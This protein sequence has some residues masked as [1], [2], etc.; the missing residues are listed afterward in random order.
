MKL[1]FGESQNRIRSMALIHEVLY[2]STDLGAVP[3][4]EYSRML[5]HQLMSAYAV[6]DVRSNM[7][8]Q[9][10]S[11]G[12]DQ[13]IPCG[14]ILNE[15]VSNALKHAFSGERSGCVSLDIGVDGGMCSIRVSDDGVGLPKEFDLLRSPTLGM[16]LL[17]TLTKQLEGRL[18]FTSDPGATFTLTFPMM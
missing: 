18:E 1:L 8:V 14:L 4:G 2:R 10:F 5:V 9:D 17:M 7:S 3:F 11:M 12:V 6:R 15:L 16:Q 13:A